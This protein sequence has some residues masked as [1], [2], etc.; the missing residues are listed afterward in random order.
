M[1]AKVP[2]SGKTQFLHLHSL[3]VHLL[4]QALVPLETHASFPRW[5]MAPANI[6]WQ[7]HWQHC[8][9]SRKRENPADSRKHHA[10]VH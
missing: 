5:T 1:A 6:V 3:Y 9:L 7:Y 2:A 8:S 4:I 10:P